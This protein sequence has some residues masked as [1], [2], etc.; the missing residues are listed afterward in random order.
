MWALMDNTVYRKC[1]MALKHLPGFVLMMRKSYESYNSK[2]SI[3]VIIASG[4]KKVLLC[5]LLSTSVWVSVII[6]LPTIILS[7]YDLQLFLPLSLQL[8]PSPLV[9]YY[10]SQHYTCENCPHA[11]SYYATLRRVCLPSSFE[12]TLQLKITDHI[13]SHEGAIHKNKSLLKHVP[14][15]AGGHKTRPYVQLSSTGNVHRQTRTKWLTVHK[16]VKPS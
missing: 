8:P 7:N 15:A 3:H 9:P 12:S 13:W 4:L 10:I 11:Y 16:K 6:S 5:L 1:P 14:A 2:V